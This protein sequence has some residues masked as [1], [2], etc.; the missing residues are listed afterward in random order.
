MIHYLLRIYSFSFARLWCFVGACLGLQFC[1]SSLGI[2]LF[3]R[4]VHI[5][6]FVGFSLIVGFCLL[7]S[8]RFIYRWITSLWYLVVCLSIFLISFLTENYIIG[9]LVNGFYALRNMLFLYAASCTASHHLKTLFF[10]NMLYVYFDRA[11]VSFCLTLCRWLSGFTVHKF[12]F[13]TESCHVPL[14]CLDAAFLEIQTCKTA[15]LTQ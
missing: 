15:F 12:M 6:W 9:S 8:F 13:I 4:Y 11:V 2:I 14:R 1:L 5:G 7:L 10:K 3:Y